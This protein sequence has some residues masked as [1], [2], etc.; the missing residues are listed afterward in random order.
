MKQILLLIKTQNYFSFTSN[1]FR[2][3]KFQSTISTILRK[4]ET[5]I[6]N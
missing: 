3:G 2:I 4:S 5:Y 6:Q 1:V